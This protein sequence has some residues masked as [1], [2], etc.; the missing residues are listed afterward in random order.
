[1]QFTTKTSA[2]EKTRCGCAIVA[3]RGGEPGAAAKA[4]DAAGGGAIGAALARG[5]LAAKAGSTLLLGPCGPAGPVSPCGPC[6]PA[7]P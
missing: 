3:V 6:G 5:D 7:S 1:M 2:P 4:L